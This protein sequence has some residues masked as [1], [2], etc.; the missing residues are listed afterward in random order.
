MRWVP[1]GKCAE[2]DVLLFGN[3]LSALFKN[4]ITV[5]TNSLPFWSPVYAGGVLC[6]TPQSCPPLASGFARPDRIVGEQVDGGRYGPLRPRPT[7]QPLARWLYRGARTYHCGPASRA[8][9][10]WHSLLGSNGRRFHSSHVRVGAAASIIQGLSAACT[11]HG[12]RYLDLA[13]K[14]RLRWPKS[15]A[16]RPAT[17]LRPRLPPRPI[18]AGLQVRDGTATERYTRELRTRNNDGGNVPLQRPR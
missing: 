9:V 3:I 7:R 12:S 17:N 16:L 18:A 1:H 10:S 2:S 6:A 5:R 14:P 8:W 15:N 13:S 11:A 4:S